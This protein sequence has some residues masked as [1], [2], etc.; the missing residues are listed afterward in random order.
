MQELTRT[1]VDRIARVKLPDVW[2]ALSPELRDAVVQRAQRESSA[3][4]AMLMETLQ[5]E[6]LDVVDLRG[7]MV[8]IV[9]AD[10]TILN[11]MFLTTGGQE[12]TFVRRSGL[13]FGFLFGLMQVTPQ[14]LRP[15]ALPL[16]FLF[17]CSGIP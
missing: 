9:L 6:I 11:D 1:L 3:Y 17:S 16:P 5:R 12:F 13:Y 4:V 10:K 15:P 2:T 7:N 14:P 8:R